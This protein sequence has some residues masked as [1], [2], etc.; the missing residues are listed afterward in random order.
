MSEGIDLQLS[1]PPLPQLPQNTQ[2]KETVVKEM[3]AEE[4]EKKRQY[5]RERKRDYRKR[6]KEGIVRQPGIRV[7]RA[8]P[9]PKVIDAIQRSE[10]IPVDPLAIDPLAIPIP[11]PAPS[12]VRPAQSSEPRVVVLTEELVKKRKYER[13]RKREYR[14]RKKEESMQQQQQQAEAENNVVQHALLDNRVVPPD[15]PADMNEVDTQ[16]QAFMV[17][18][19]DF[20]GTHI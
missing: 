1:M 11:I 17:G 7:K 9:P 3:T 19:V 14:R 13:E 6:K 20:S 2:R 12:P 4:R 15:M 18:P 16:F 10:P 5:E 8:V